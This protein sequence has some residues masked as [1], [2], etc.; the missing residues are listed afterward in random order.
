MLIDL[1]ALD[2]NGKDF[3]FD[4]MSDELSGAFTDLIG[5]TPFQI[6]LEIKPLGNTFLVQGSLKSQYPEVCSR[7]GFDIDV[8]LF[9]RINEIVVVEKER[10]RNTQVSQSRQNFDA[11]D[12]SVTYINHPQFDLKEFLHE[13]MAASFQLYPVCT[14]KNKCEEQRPKF[15]QEEAPVVKGHPGFEALKNLKLNN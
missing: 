12:P 2:E 3:D 9:N 13:M 4:Q 6:H 11:A 5:K 14:D 10:P 1:L 8:P 15:I 7:C